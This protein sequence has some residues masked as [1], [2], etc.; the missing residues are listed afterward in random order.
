MAKLP[1]QSVDCVLTDLP[2]ATTSNA[3]DVLIPFDDL[4]AAWKRVCKPAAP[5]VLFSQQPFT[6][7]LAASNLKQ[8]RT[9]W[10]WEKSQGTGFLNSNRYPLK[11]H[12]NILV[13]SEKAPPYHPQKE[14]GHKTY[15]TGRG[16]SSTNYRKFD[17]ETQTVNTDGSRYPKTVLKFNSDKGYHPT[18]KPIA[19]LEYL[20]RTYTNESDT[21][22]DCTMGSGST[23]LA[24]LNTNRRC[25]GIE[26]DETYF[27]T[28]LVRI[29]EAYPTVSMHDWCSVY[30]LPYRFAVNI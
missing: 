9:E 1:A 29:E 28:A 26:R 18:Q 11:N 19:L 14:Y 3:W 30:S 25:I 12:E 22:L 2:F 20:I 24:S 7:S 10:I 4:W 23:L 21:V 17:K 13:F 8:L 5:I 27:S 15:T 16:R 6:T